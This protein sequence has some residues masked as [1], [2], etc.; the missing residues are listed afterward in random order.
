MANP[1]IIPLKIGLFGGQGSGKTT[2]AALIAAALSKE[3]HGG[4]P[5]WVTDTEP[6][7]QFVRPRI[8]TPEKIELVTRKVP[9]FK[10]MLSDIYEAQKA[11][12]CVWAADQLTVIWAELMQSFKAKN[13]GFIPINVWGD[14]RQMWNEYISAFRNSGMHCIAIGRL[15]NVMEEMQGD[16]EGEL[17]LVKTGTTFKAGGSESFGYEPDWLCELSLERKPKVLRGKGPLPV[18]GEGRMIHRADVLKDRTWSTNGR[19]FRWGDKPSYKPGGYRAVWQD[20]LPY[21]EAVQQTGEHSQLEEGTSET[22]IADDGRGDYYHKQRMRQ[23]CLEDWDAT[24]E[25]MFPGSTAAMKRNRAVVGEAITGVRSRTRLE[26]YDVNQLQ[27]CIGILMALEHRLKAE[28]VATESDL[29]RMLELAK[30][31]FRGAGGQHRTLLEARLKESLALVKPNGK[32]EAA[33]AQPF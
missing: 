18:E 31:D 6:G 14:I 16:K 33:Q 10:A 1:K 30:E 8:F 13:G 5:V 23:M 19:V 3:L 17:R 20:L 15:G 32:A 29:L 24:M 4:A 28:P 25:L 21:Y 27:Q 11:G 12:A 22:A 9:T 26:Q 2:T 7:W